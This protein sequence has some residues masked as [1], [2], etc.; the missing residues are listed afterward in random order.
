[1]PYITSVAGTVI[2]ASW[3]NTN[4]RDQVV[5][6]FADLATATA[7]IGTPVEGM[8]ISLATDPYGNTDM[9]WTY[10]GSA[11]VPAAPERVDDAEWTTAEPATTTE[12]LVTGSSI[13]FTSLP[14]RRYRAYLSTM[15]SSTVAGDNVR[16]R[17]RSAIGA[18]VDATGTL[19]RDV[20]FTASA[21]N[22]TTPVSF[23]E[24][25]T[26]FTGGQRT[27]GLFVLRYSGTGTVQT[28]NA[29]GSMNSM[30]I[31]DVGPA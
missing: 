24:E 1:M 20:V 4:I 3:A 19:R 30:V 6:P 22:A 5:T 28:G 26:G 15:Y 18:S 13:T 29:V 27:V 14:D 25:I 21:V 9:L 8:L 31:D 16:L 12:T 10:A 23:T 11:W 2:T 17:L 7:T